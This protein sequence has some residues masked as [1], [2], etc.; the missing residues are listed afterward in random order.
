MKVDG[1]P[2]CRRCLQEVLPLSRNSYKV[3]VCINAEIDDVKDIA[4]LTKLDKESVKT[5]IALLAESKF[6]NVS[7]MLVFL[8][9]KITADG[10]RTL[11]VYSK[12]YGED[13]DVAE[14]D[15]KI[16]EFLEAKTNGR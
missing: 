11:K 15:E 14:V 1:R 7:G 16:S 9:R 10:V 2:Y 13:E 8:K 5:T 3:L 12:V 6:V 4:D